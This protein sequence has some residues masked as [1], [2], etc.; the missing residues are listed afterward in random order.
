MEELTPIE[1]DRMYAVLVQYFVDVTRPRFERDLAEKEW[2]ILLADT[3]QGQIQ[4]FSTLMR[5]HSVVDEHPVVAFFSGDTIIHR[6]YWG[7]AALPRLWG[8]H[9]FG[10][11]ESIRDTR[12]YWY[13]IS[14]GYK[15]YRFLPLFFRKFYP[16]YKRPTPPTVKRVLDALGRLKFPSEYD[17]ERGVV[18]F[19]EATPLQSG[20]AEVT[21]RHLRNPHIA[22]FVTANPGHV[23]GDELACLA[24]LTLANLTRAGRRM[25][26]PP[27]DIRL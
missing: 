12:V 21:E 22:F 10:L 2:A 26:E 14:S 1:R 3:S 19:V 7:E 5:L 24:E 16:T 23:H 8:Q 13:L 9:V 4:G 27:A 15:T 6:K 20:V 18:R 11:A 17:P 25:L